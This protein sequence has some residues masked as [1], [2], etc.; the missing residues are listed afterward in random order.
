MIRNN[1]TVSRLIELIAFIIAFIITSTCLMNALIVK[2]HSTEARMY[3]VYEGYAHNTDVLFIGSSHAGHLV[4]RNL[5]RDYGIAAYTIAGNSQPVDILYH[6]IVEFL[7]YETPKVIMVETALI[8]D[9]SMESPDTEYE[10]RIQNGAGFRYSSNYLQMV[11]EQIKNFNL[12]LKTE[13]IQLIYKWPLMHDRYKSL[14][15]DDFVPDTPYFVSDTEPLYSVPE[16][17]AQIVTSEERG[18]ISDIGREYLDKIIDLC[19]KEN[20]PLVLFHTPYPAPEITLAQQNTIADIA[21][22]NNVP[23]ID[24][25]YLVDDIGFDVQTDQAR[26]LN[27]LNLQGGEKVT[28]YLGKY[29]LNNYGLKDHR[30]DPGYDTWNKDLQ[31]W[32]TLQVKKSFEEAGSTADYAE[33]L[34]NQ[35]SNYVV[36]MTL[37]GD[38]FSE[39]D[40]SIESVLGKVP[41]PQD[42]QAKG[43]TVLLDHG[44]VLFY[45][46]DN[47]TYAFSHKFGNAIV[48]VNR[49]IP[50]DEF[51][52]QQ[53]AENNNDGIYIWN[54]N[55][56]QN[57][58]G[59][60]ITIYDSDLDIVINSI[61]IDPCTGEE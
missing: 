10:G 38:Y 47:A 9:D 6:S 41:V 26:D 44:N 53:N 46:A 39:S 13:G 19:Q 40:G 7:K 37:S 57:A 55:Y 21:A 58:N 17:E 25:N 56:I 12:P 5:W 8:P 45:S 27:H 22:E 60:N 43:G 20:V 28:D 33:L 24:F 50:N 2:G 52:S 11:S 42:F 30:Q 4:G 31:G 59:L 14:T 16:Q 36:I 54:D 34:G 48:S 18:P 1:Q 32:Q 61:G 29:L 49:H 23:F 35:Y 3:D 15:K 51:I